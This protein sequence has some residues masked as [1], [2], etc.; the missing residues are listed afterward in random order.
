MEEQ[1]KLEE[2]IKKMVIKLLAEFFDESNRVELSEEEVLKFDPEQ[3]EFYSRCHPDCP[4]FGRP[5]PHSPH[6]PLYP[7][8]WA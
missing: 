8:Y 5:M 3:A 7:T 1:I 2:N 4:N 6:K